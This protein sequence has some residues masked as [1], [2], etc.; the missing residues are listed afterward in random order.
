MLLAL[1]VLAIVS[2]VGRDLFALNFYF[3]SHLYLQSSL[4]DVEMFI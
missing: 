3:K 1:C 4:A 2:T